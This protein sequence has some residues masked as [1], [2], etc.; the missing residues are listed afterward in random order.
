MDDV[1]LA[2]SGIGTALHSEETA[3]Y[4]PVHRTYFGYL[5]ATA[6]VPHRSGSATADSPDCL[7]QEFGPNDWN[8]V[9]QAGL[10]DLDLRCDS[11]LAWL[12]N[13]K[14]SQSPLLK[15]LS[16]TAT[17][18]QAILRFAGASNLAIDVVAQAF[19]YAADSVINYNSRLLF[20]IDTSTVQALVLGRQRDFRTELVGMMFNN[21][22][23]VEHALRSYLR[24]CLPFTIETDINNIITVYQRTEAAPSSPLISAESSRA[25]IGATRRL[26]ADMPVSTTIVRPPV[27]PSVRVTELFAPGSR[28]G[29][30][31]VD[32]VQEAFCLS[33]G[34]VGRQTKIAVRIFE[35]YRGNS[36]LV[37]KD[38]R[39]TD[40][41]EYALAVKSGK[42]DAAQFKNIHEVEKL[43]TP[44]RVKAF[45]NRLNEKVEGDPVNIEAGL[46]DPAVRKKI[47]QANQHFQIETYDD[48][49][50]DQVLPALYS[51]LGIAAPN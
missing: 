23:A 34:P 36:P 48:I 35:T 3:A 15:Q 19:G 29:D 6:E 37:K 1:R 18:T 47:A 49:A 24:I 20:E 41:D 43:N 50:K 2:S 9:V 32:Q 8:T 14:R 31:D 42:C 13:R 28:Y 46:N 21:K 27:L 7:Y 45:L 17:R 44:A 22:P 10:N 25:A 16:D 33:P 4:F 40:K 39:I 5:C 26:T 30:A 11:Y 51:S 12:D 38:G